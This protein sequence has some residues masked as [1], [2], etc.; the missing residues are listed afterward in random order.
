MRSVLFTIMSLA[1]ICAFTVSA[2][3]QEREFVPVTDAMLQ[4]PAPADWPS[5]RRTPNLWG[6]SPLD[7]ITR[8]NVGQ[9][10]LVWTRPLGPGV[11]EGTPLVYDGV[12]YFPNPSDI[13]QAIDAA[14]GDLIW[15]YRR[16]VQD[17][18]GD[19]IAF[20]SINRNLA[21]YGTLIFDNGADNYAYAL[22]ARTGKLAWETQILDYRK[23]AQHSSGPMIANGKV[24]SGRSCEPEAGP[25]ACI[26]VAFDALTGRE[27]WRTRLIPRP[28]EPGDETWGGV[29]YEERR[30]VGSW[31]VPSFDPELNRIY[32]GTSVTAPAPK[33]TLAGNDKQYLY[34]NSTLALDA[35]TGE[36][37]WY[38][39]HNTDHW[40][41]DHP[42]ERMIVDTEVAPDAR[43][44]PW[45]NPRVRPGQTYKVI[46]GVP[47][48][49][50]LVYT[51]DRETGQFLWARP[52]VYQNVIESVNT[53]SGTGVVNP[54]TMF[55]AA[56][57]E[58]MVCPSLTGGKN[59]HAGAYSPLTRLM[60]FPLQNVCMQ[61][62]ATTA[63][64]TVDD[65]YAISSTNEIA[66]GTDNVGTIEA[67][68]VETGETAW[69]HEQRAGAT[70]LV[71][72]GGGL[73]FGGDVQGR[74]RAFDQR[75][76]EVLWEVNLGSQVTGFPV[77]FAVGG[78]QYIAISTG[79]APNTFGLAALTPELRA[80]T[81]N[82]LYVFAL[83]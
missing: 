47:G 5:W 4:N 74:F 33:F 80:G 50:G 39:Q 79:G 57:Q 71:A 13:T 25:V 49:T 69:K 52:T 36:I 42:F 6:Y 55:T 54:D 70:S 29:P 73:L 1:L 26:I 82:N 35:D 61:I 34:H 72:T 17:D 45:I 44:V 58:R 19:Y 9:L 83:P 21:I 75:T 78:K 43:A 40:D 37:V 38:L 11:Q 81:A 14:S 16:P 76:G 67:I 77:T 60:Y 59:Y 18:N 28:G 22:D 65:V 20:P 62:T 56:G 10:R 27:L 3:A 63:T 31:M 15:E 24:V 48:K 66:P 30:Q 68:S 2:S 12:M 41:L 8:R 23:G 64:P 51:I 53:E 46:T 32:V 7:Q